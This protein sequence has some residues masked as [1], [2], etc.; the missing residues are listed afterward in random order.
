MCD[1]AT[2]TGVGDARAPPRGHAP[3]QTVAPRSP[4]SSERPDRAEP[5]R[6]GHDHETRRGA[7]GE[8]RRSDPAAAGAT[9]TTPSPT[10][11]GTPPSVQSVRPD[12]T[13][14]RRPDLSPC[15]VYIRIFSSQRKNRRGFRG[16]PPPP[17]R[18]R[19]PATV[20]A[21][22]PGPQALSRSPPPRSRWARAPRRGR[23]RRRPAAR[24]RRG[25]RRPPRRARRP[26][27]SPPAARRQAHAH[28]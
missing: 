16:R 1:L 6:R 24:S 21:A 14:R 27:A 26:R 5:E 2:E 11:N 12:V 15:E 3:R 13:A 10:R 4:R 17:A 22:D 8:S 25:C 28:R 23:P 7:R 20:W 9:R 18:R 19:A